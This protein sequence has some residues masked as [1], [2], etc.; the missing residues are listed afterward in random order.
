M[1]QLSALAHHHEAFL[2]WLRGL[3]GEAEH[4]ETHI[5][6]IFLT[7]QWAYKLKKPLKLSFLDF[8]ALETRRYYTEREL[9][10]NQRTAP[11]MYRDVLPVYMLGEDFFWERP[12]ANAAPVDYVLKMER[13]DE[14]LRMDR[15]L[16]TN[17]LT[18]K[19]ILRLVR[20]VSNFHQN[21]E[22]I[23]HGLDPKVLREQ[24][25][26]L[27]T[28]A[29]WVARELGQEVAQKT[30]LGIQKADAWI[31]AHLPLFEHRS[32]HRWVRDVHGDLH[33]RNIFLYEAP[34][35][36]DCIEFNDAF[37]QIDV[38]NDIAFLC[39]DLEALGLHQESTQVWN[40]YREAMGIED[41]DELD[42]L[43]TFYKS[44]RANVR[45]KIAALAAQE[46]EGEEA[47]DDI[48]QA[49]VYARLFGY[50]WK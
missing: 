5:S 4:V 34:V 16:K 28:V 50:Y 25:L 40:S 49:E 6:H 38:L 47:K 21:A 44:Y 7:P 26:D 17:P 10:L 27:R 29:S 14:S 13:M 41:D 19:Q 12:L 2:E 30:E 23:A 45:L 20:L 18:T 36:F 37:R 43:F 8:S 39:M 11:R 24:Y 48:Q 31:N 32:R 33:T 46:K 1:E 9:R 35:V 15:W 22:A 3:E 42:G